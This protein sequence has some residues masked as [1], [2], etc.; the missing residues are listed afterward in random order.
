MIDELRLVEAFGENWDAA[1]EGYKQAKRSNRQSEYYLLHT[2]RNELDIT[3]MDAF[4]RKP[5]AS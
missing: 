2:D 4:R 1:W 3:V 5:D